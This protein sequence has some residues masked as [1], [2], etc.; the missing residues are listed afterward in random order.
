[1]K[2][3]LDIEMPAGRVAGEYDDKFQGVVDAFVQNFNERDEVGASCV[4]SL[5]GENLVDLWGGR[6]ARNGEAWERDTLCT[7]FSST[8]GGMSLCAHMLADRDELDLDALV[9][10]YWPEFGQGGKESGRVKMALDH[11]L[12]VPHVRGTVPAGGFYDYDAMVKR[13][14]AEP[15]FWE[16]GSR[17]GYHAITM[18]WT[19]GEI[20]H[21]A[22]NKRMG[23][24][25]DDE[26]A[27]PLG[28]E[29]W[30]GAPD[31]VL[32]K[33]SPMIPAE[34]DEPW[35]ATRFIQAALSKEETP[36]QLFMRD[37]QVLN[38][39]EVACHQAEVGSANGIANARGLAGMYAPLANG[40]ELNGVRLVGAD[41]LARMGR[42]SMASHDDASLLIPTRFALGYMKATDNRKTPNT[43]NASLLVGDDAFGHVGAG[44]S[45]GFADPECKLSFG[46]AMNRMGTGLLM[47]ERGQSLVDATYDALGYRSNASGA[48]RT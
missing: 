43:V 9:T 24:F 32:S 46:Y 37:F 14:E 16:P 41:T 34:P 8:K 20:V 18:A 27:K 45:L 15:A 10:D 28:I 12:G 23:K 29:F 4:V 13:I 38:P 6:T 21:R 36:T 11:S 44:G 5:E 22:A 7:V 40:G 35:L 33:I 3:T 1:M 30:I 17:G 19:V 47:N 39:N 25:F 2:Q 48:W 31:S 26:I 42:V